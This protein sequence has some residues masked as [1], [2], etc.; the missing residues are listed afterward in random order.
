LVWPWVVL[1]VPLRRLIPLLAAL[2]V[3]APLFRLW[4]SYHFGAPWDTVQAAPLAVAD[5]LAIGA[6][7]A[8]AAQRGRD[9]SRLAR[10]RVLPAYPH[11]RMTGSRRASS[12]CSPTRRSPCCSPRS[13]S[14]RAS[15]SA[16]RSVAPSSGA[17]SSTWAASATA[18]I[19]SMHPSPAL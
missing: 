16:A 17:R 5:S 19:S 10:R 8:L 12:S 14:P 4:A 6:L 15:A 13:S 7:V 3:A 9:V 2:I 11:S 18:S 1:F